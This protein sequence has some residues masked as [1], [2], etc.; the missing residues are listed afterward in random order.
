MSEKAACALLDTLMRTGISELDILGGEPMLVPYIKDF[1]RY[2]TGAGI[3]VNISTNGSLPEIVHT[4]AK[5]PTS[6]LNIGFSLHGFSDTHN[7]ITMSDNFNSVL[8][9]IRK[10]IEEGKNPVVKSVLTRTNRGEIHALIHY[11]GELGVKRYFLLH[12]DIIG[13]KLHA[14][15][16]SFP[17]FMRYFSTLKSSLSDIPDIGFVAAS[18]FYKCGSP[19]YRRCDAGTTKL[20][21]LPD[22]STFPCN[23]LLGFKEFCLGNIL[24]DEFETILNHPILQRFRQFNGNVCSYIHC[25]RY[26]SCGGGCPA[27]S[28]YF[29]RN[30]GT[31]D[32]R[33]QFI[34]L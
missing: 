24:R 27:H 2:V 10:T 22:S 31:P 18:G 30:L 11:L 16:L 23:L 14:G 26:E 3:T 20:A 21:V 15:C 17:D 29:Y 34:S 28:Y 6:L 19:A 9:G 5:I 13:R 25:T 1:V 7:A 32:P 12:E 33:C 8:E 4:V